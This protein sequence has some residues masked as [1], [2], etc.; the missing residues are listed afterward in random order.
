VRERRAGGDE[1]RIRPDARRFENWEG[2]VAG[3][4]G[5]GVA[6]DYALSIG[7]EAI[8]ERCSG[9]R[10]CQCCLPPTRGSTS[11]RAASTRPYALGAL[12]QHGI[13]ARSPP[14]RGV[15]LRERIALKLIRKEGARGS[16]RP[17]AAGPRAVTVV[18]PPLTRF[19]KARP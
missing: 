6:A 10:P 19:G 17:M 15:R 8:R 11:A 16:E 9:W 1:Y 18:I 4:I 13:R 2:F 7:L 5:L 14:P 3:K 12:L